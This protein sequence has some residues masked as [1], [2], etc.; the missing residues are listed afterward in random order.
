MALIQTRRDFI[1]GIAR[2]ATAGLVPAPGAAATEGALEITTVRLLKSS[3]I[4]R[5]PQYVAEALLQAEGFSDIRHVERDS[6][7]EFNEALAQNQADFGTH[8]SAELLPAIEGGAAI[9][10]LSGVHVGCQKLFARDEIRS[11]TDLKGRS[12]A[13]SVRTS[14]PDVLVSAMVA[15]VGLDPA[16][17]I[18][19]VVGKSPTPMQLFT[20]GK[21]DAFVA[22]P[23]EPQEL[24]ARHIGHV[25]VNTGL[26]R[27]W[28]QYFCCMFAANRDFVRKH[29]VAT[30]RVLRAVLKAADFCAAE[31]ARAARQLVDGDFTP[32][33]DYALQAMQDVVYGKWRD[34]DAEDTVRFYALLLRDAGLIKSTPQKIIAD[35]TNWRFLDELKR[36]LKA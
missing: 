24:R 35:G 26:D 14:M 27:P 34:Y 32:R 9:T 28:S 19:W 12:V 7:A 13:I 10:I 31:P 22:T 6:S 23:T 17:D 29:P 1:S 8:Y 11:I 21:V 4:C 20:D 3:G 36:E 18:R 5:A 2:A 33:Y 25:L 16:R 30:K 15:R